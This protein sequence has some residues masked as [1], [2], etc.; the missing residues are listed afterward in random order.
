MG[1]FILARMKAYFDLIDWQIL[2]IFIC[3]SSRFLVIKVCPGLLLNKPGL[4]MEQ[5]LQQ[6]QILSP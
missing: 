1:T 6:R 2:F 5:K 3:I 4:V